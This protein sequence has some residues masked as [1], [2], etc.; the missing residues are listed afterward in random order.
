MNGPGELT[1]LETRERFLPVQTASILERVL[2]DPRFSARERDQFAT[3]FQMIQARF[4]FEFLDLTERL[5]IL[6]DPFDP[7]RDT[8]ALRRLTAEE[9]EEQFAELR[10]CYRKLLLDG[11]YVELTREQLIAC[12]ESQN[13]MGLAVKVNLDD[14]A[15]LRVFYR[16][17]REGKRA[18]R[19]WRTGWM[20]RLRPV[21]LFSRVA[22][23]VRRIT[24]GDDSVLLKLF[25][26]VVVEDLEMMSPEVRIGMRPFDRLKIGS[27]VAGGLFAP[28]LKLVMA[29]AISPMLLLMVVGGCVAAFF[30]GVFSF[31]TCKTKYMQTLSSSLY[32]QN[33]ANNASALTRLV[34]AAEAEEAKELLLAYYLLYLER[35]RDYTLEE[36]DQRVEEWLREQFDLDVD[37]EV[38]DAI[39][40]L[41]EK[42][43]IVQRAAQPASTRPPGAAAN[44][45]TGD[46][47]SRE[48]AP[49]RIFKVYDLPTA[50]RR[51]DEWWDNYFT[52]NNLGDPADDRVADGDWPP[53]AQQALSRPHPS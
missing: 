13:Y 28:I 4:H 49:R 16:G 25:K 15:E 22:L 12:L 46:P 3:L 50:L 19:S 52:A 18:F 14:Y 30:K 1:F 36:L 27:T 41:I 35:D 51:L 43:L 23:L 2:E 21:R 53:H 44:E 24:D 5:K 45:G 29:A 34:D 26:D 6:Y 10:E 39:R 40:K 31:L 47:E 8:L 7:D 20:K 38:D 17:I 11:N 33:L 37:F 42:D 9:R 32:F 48:P